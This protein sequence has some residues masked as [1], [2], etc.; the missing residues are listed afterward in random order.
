MPKEVLHRTK[1]GF[2][3]SL[4]SLFR[5]QADLVGQRISSTA[6]IDSG[7][8]SVEALKQVIEEH[9]TGRFDHSGVLWLLLVFEGFLTIAGHQSLPETS[10]AA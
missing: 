7:L 10:I 1:Q 6:M 9:E 2:A 4:A 3:T 8:F 5:E